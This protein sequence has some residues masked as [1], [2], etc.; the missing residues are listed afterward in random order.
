MTWKAV[1]HKVGLGVI[2]MKCLSNNNLRKLFRRL[3]TKK[4]IKLGQ[5]SFADKRRTLQDIFPLP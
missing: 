5:K 3:R 4:L 1:V 2:R